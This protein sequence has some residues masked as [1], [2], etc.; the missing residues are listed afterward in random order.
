[1][2]KQ[3]AVIYC[4]V[5]SQRQVDEGNGLSSQEFRCR[6]FAKLKNYQVT[7]V[8]KDKGVSGSLLERQ[9]INELTDYLNRYKKQ[10]T[11]IVVVIDDINRLARDVIAY[12][13]LK[14][15]LKSYNARLDSPN[16]DFVDT[17]ENHFLENIHASLAQYHREQNAKQVVSRTKARLEQGYWTFNLPLGY[18]RIKDD[19]KNKI[20]IPDKPVS[21]IIQ[22]A[23]NGF[24]SNRFQS[25]KEVQDFLLSKSEFPRNSKGTVYHQFVG[26]M[27]RNPLYAGFI[28]KPEWDIKMH[29]GNHEAIVSPEVFFQ[30]QDKLERK[31]YAP[32]RKDLNKD[33]TLRG[34]ITCES[35]RK[36]FTASWSKGR[37]GRHAYY[38]CRSKEGVRKGSSK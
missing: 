16:F 30:V 14:A 6:Q 27:L 9:G 32:K 31:A 12:H 13:T 35:C 7:K 10:K 17:P 3:E 38:R 34:F 20:L 33:F 26:Q 22:E 18:K 5:S 23:F 15:L 21:K 19:L 37:N 29:K 11:E 24:A 8:F 28:H 4:R 1:M 36:T 2:M 25:T